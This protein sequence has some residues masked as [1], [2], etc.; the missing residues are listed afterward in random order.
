MFQGGAEKL[1]ALGSGAPPEGEQKESWSGRCKPF[2]CLFPERLGQLEGKVALEAR[3]CGQELMKSRRE[4]P[5]E[6]MPLVE[7]G[8]G[9]ACV[10]L[11]WELSWLAHLFL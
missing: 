6:G 7:G 8:Q 1:E 9:A 3:F 10:W 5:L 2:S 11:Q 4:A